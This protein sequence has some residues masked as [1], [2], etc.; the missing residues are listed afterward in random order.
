MRMKKR[1][2]A[3]F[4]CVIVL[5]FC[6]ILLGLCWGS[7]EISVHEVIATLLGNGT[8]IQNTAIFGIRLPRIL[9]GIFVAAG[10]AISGGV[11]QTMTRNELADPGIIGI[12]AGGATAAVLFIQCQAGLI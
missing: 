4:A 8:K 7:Y 2:T 10:L 11:L 5:F 9:L 12:N 1:K 6:A 3:V